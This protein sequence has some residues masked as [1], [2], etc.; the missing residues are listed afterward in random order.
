MT[1]P[2]DRVAIPTNGHRPRLGD[3]DLSGTDLDDTTDLG[4]GTPSFTLPPMRPVVPNVTPTQ[5]AVGF[6]IVAA[7]ILLVLGRRRGGRG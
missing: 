3:D 5:A 7:L 1:Q 6:G 4:A 2:E